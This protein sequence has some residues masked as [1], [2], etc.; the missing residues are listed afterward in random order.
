MLRLTAAIVGVAATA[1]LMALP[2]GAAVNT[3]PGRSTYGTAYLSNC[4]VYVGDK[5]V[6]PAYAEGDTQVVCS[7]YHTIA[8]YTQLERAPMAGGTWQ[9]VESSAGI[10]SAYTW[11]AENWTYA[12]TVPVTAQ[13][14]TLSW[15]SL[16]G[17]AWHSYYGPT[18]VYTPA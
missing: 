5:A 13:W 12:Y 2:A 1:G 16:D 7:T 6:V 4:T 3:T 11:N 15:V 10:S 18:G 14:R 8:I 17:G 9:V